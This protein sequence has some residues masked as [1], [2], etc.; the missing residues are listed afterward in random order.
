MNALL[1][2]PRYPE[3]F[4]SFKHVL[5]FVSKK[6]AFP[7][8]GLLTIAAMLPEE[9]EKRLVDTNVQELKEEDI[10]WSDMVFISAMI[11]QKS[12]AQEI[13]GR[14]KALGKKVVAGGPVFTT[15]HEKFAGVDH[16]VL[17]EAE[18]TLPMFLEDLKSGNP[19]PIYSS[20]ER[21]DITK[22]PLP[23]WSLINFKDYATMLVQNSRGC[24]FNCEFC[25]IVIMNG[26]VPRTKTSEQLIGEMQLLYDRG[27]KGS[28]FIVDDNFIGNKVNVKK[29]LPMLAE[30]QKAHNY[31]FILLT[32]AS[33][34]LADD[35]ELMQMMSAANF[36]KVFLGIE[37]PNLDSLKECGKLQ[38]TTR[39]L[40]ETVK[41]IQQ[42]GMQVMGGFIV[43]FDSDT[44]TVFDAQIDFI[45]Q[46][47][48]ATA[49]V[50]LLAALPQTRLWHRLKR[51]GRLLGDST[52]NI[53]GSMN[54]IP[55]MDKANLI[56]GYRKI[57]SKI[58][59]PGLYYQRIETFVRN[60]KPTV[61]RRLS[62]I[63]LKA[64]FESMWRI[65]VLS[66]ARL[67]YWRLLLRTAFTKAKAL[68]SAIELAVWGLHFE[69]CAK[70][71]IKNLA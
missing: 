70:K 16:F 7:P 59:S 57:L 34:N 10:M 40:A 1:V 54:F 27:W 58:Y 50:G 11:V 32:E 62:A 71:A 68:P 4:W 55:K 14:C 9:W 20:A 53:D 36:N 21:P 48:V 41:T 12:S 66:K 17:N 61:K 30:W 25:D 60:Y 63:N 26:N 51:E 22:T 37:T 31:P 29:M 47:G 5:R 67:H 65:G 15:Q 2:Y 44:E 42:N 43:G 19:K 35:K 24:P 52:G 13:I 18:A 49:M 64:L 6:A 28:V 46:A 33:T 23:L 39:N 38:N 3:T 45:Q 56:A 8:L 69:K